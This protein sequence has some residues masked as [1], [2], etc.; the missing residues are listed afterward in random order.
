M[1]LAQPAKFG[2]AWSD[3]RIASWLE[4]LPAAGEDPDY[5]VLWRAYQG[6]RAHDF[7][8]FTQ[9][10]LEQGRNINALG[11]S[12]ETLT[13]ILSRHRCSEDFLHILVDAGGR[14]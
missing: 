8:R 11:L 3:E 4:L 7:E 10:F 2:E 14:A 9:L 12:G 6:M 13:S 1:A 5:H